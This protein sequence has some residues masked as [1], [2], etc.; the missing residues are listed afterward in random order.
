MIHHKL[1]WPPADCLGHHLNLFPNIIERTMWN[2]LPSGASNWEENLFFIM[3]GNKKKI[4]FNYSVT[5][6]KPRFALPWEWL[7]AII[8]TTCSQHQWRHA[9]RLAS[10]PQRQ[11]R[12]T[13]LKYMYVHMYTDTHTCITYWFICNSWHFGTI[14]CVFWKAASVL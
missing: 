12:K 14:G 4:T 8:I 3:T 7:L 6:M 11:R 13:V 9:V 2:P 1:N 5:L 10:K